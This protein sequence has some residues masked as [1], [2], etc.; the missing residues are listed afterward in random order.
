MKISSNNLMKITLIIVD[1]DA[2][3]REEKVQFEGY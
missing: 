2:V 3:F 1:V